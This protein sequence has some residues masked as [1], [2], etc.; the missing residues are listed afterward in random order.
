MN[1][2]AQRWKGL[3]LIEL[4]V[5]VAVIAI[6][7]TIAYPYYTKQAQKARRADAKAALEAIAL[8]EERYYT[9]NGGYGTLGSL[10]L[11]SDLSDGTSARG[12]YSLSVAGP[13]VS[14]TS[15][16]FT[17]TATPVSGGAQDSDSDCASFSI[18]Q[19]GTRTAT[20]DNASSC[21]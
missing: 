6:L 14:G 7:G 11:E 5:V 2:Q 10:T 17:A 4:L 12:Y 3:T 1:S 20:G 8:A 16:S 9:A 21:W 18:N 15:Q 19:L 13:T